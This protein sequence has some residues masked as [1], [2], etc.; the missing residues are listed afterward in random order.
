MIVVHAHETDH[1]PATRA[2]GVAL[3]MHPPVGP[4]LLPSRPAR[5][6]VWLAAPCVTPLPRTP[7]LSLPPAAA[8]I[9][10]L[11]PLCTLVTN[12]LIFSTLPLR[13]FFIGASACR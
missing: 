11:D 2:A 9:V 8:A 10:T 12:T 6:A 3:P 13:C 7:Y 1:E 4:P 5:L